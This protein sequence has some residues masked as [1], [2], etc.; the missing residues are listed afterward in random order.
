VDEK[1]NPKTVHVSMLTDKTATREYCPRESA[2]AYRH[3]LESGDFWI[4]TSM[5]LTFD[6]G[7]FVHGR[8]VHS[9]RAF[10]LGDWDCP[11]CNF[12][13]GEYQKCS[14]CGAEPEYHELFWRSPI[15]GVIGSLD[16]V[17]DLE[18]PKHVIVEIK[19]LEKDKFK[20][21]K[22]PL[23]E[24][25][26]R[27]LGYLKLLREANEVDPWIGENI[28]LDVG[29]VLY[30]SKGMGHYFQ[31]K[32]MGGVTERYSPFQE[33]PVYVENNG[34]WDIV[35]EMFARAK[36]YWAW[37]NEETGAVLPSRILNCTHDKCKRAETCTATKECWNGE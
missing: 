29:Y 5:A 18:Y 21:L 16:M 22:M 35:E 24:H 19:T 32:G 20:E 14:K 3:D 17:V 7:T 23:S 11:G 33:F 31:K 26:Q 2:L 6:I 15:S 36:D 10:A 8:V 37:K 25:R 27:V 28:M 12:W 9:L 30:A 34:A 4:S 1:R 13:R